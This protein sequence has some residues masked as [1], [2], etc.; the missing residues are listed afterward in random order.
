MWLHNSKQG[1]G[2]GYE[3]KKKGLFLKG[4]QGGIKDSFSGFDIGMDLLMQRKLRE[5]KEGRVCLVHI[6]SK[7][8]K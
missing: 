4:K 6:K 5:N 2:L 3:K 7:L 8:L 1:W